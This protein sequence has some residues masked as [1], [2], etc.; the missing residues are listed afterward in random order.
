[1]KRFVG[2]FERGQR[3]LFP[4]CLDDW[5]FENGPVRV[6]DVFVDERDLAARGFHRV[7]PTATGRPSYHWDIRIDAEFRAGNSPDRVT[8]T[9][10]SQNNLWRETP[11]SRIMRLP[12]RAA[13]Q[14]SPAAVG[15]SSNPRADKAE[16]SVQ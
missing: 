16:L 14:R 15:N 10:V 7:D 4:E 2:G 1:M 8:A 5:I 11:V 12:Q 9:Q 13:R 6:I 3:T